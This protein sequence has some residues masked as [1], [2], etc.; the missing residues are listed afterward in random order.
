MA[1]CTMLSSPITQ[2]SGYLLVSST[3]VLHVPC[4]DQTE[5]KGKAIPSSNPVVHAIPHGTLCSLI[6]CLSTTVGIP[7]RPLCHPTF[8]FLRAWTPILIPMIPMIPVLPVSAPVIPLGPIILQIGISRVIVS[9]SRLVRRERRGRMGG[10]G[11]GGGV[12][13]KVGRDIGESEGRRTASAVLPGCC[14]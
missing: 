11:K 8:V 12:R 5:N 10:R 2:R 1:P 7:Q 9:H 4:Q 6:H 14:M 3:P 13:R